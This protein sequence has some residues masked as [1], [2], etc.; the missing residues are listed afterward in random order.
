MSVKITIDTSDIQDFAKA[1]K[2]ESSQ[3]K[4]NLHQAMRSNALDVKTTAKRPGYVPYKTGNLR[5]SITHK[6]NVGSASISA[7]IGSNLDYAAI[8][9]FGGQAGRG[10]N[11][12]IKPSRYIQRAI[13]DNEAKLIAR[14]KQAIAIGIIK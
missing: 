6:I 11:V 1:L 14:I 12:T 9:E 5:R 8:H 13:E 4:T 3:L 2:K 10:G 7:I